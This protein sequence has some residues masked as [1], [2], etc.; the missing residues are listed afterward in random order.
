MS[1]DAILARSPFIIYQPGGT[2]TGLVVTSWTQVQKFIVAREGS[3]IVYI[4]DS[5]TSPATV[6]AATGITDGLGRL[7]IRPYRDNSDSFSTLVIDD[8]ATLKGILRIS[9]TVKVLADT[10]SATPGF[11]WDYSGAATPTV[12][13]EDGGFIG[14]TTTATNPSIVVPAAE[15]LAILFSNFGGVLVQMSTAFIN[16]PAATSTIR[17]ACSE[18]SMFGPGSTVPVPASWIT[19]PGESFISYDSRTIPTSNGGFPQSSAA[20][21]KSYQ[22]D[23]QQF[24]MIFTATTPNVLGSI[25]NGS[26]PFFVPMLPKIGSLYCELEG[27]GGTGGGGGGSAGGAANGVGGGGSGGATLQRA[28]FTANLTN[29]LDITIGAGGTAGAAGVAPAGAGG[30]G[31]DGGSTYA[32]DATT[33]FILALLGGTS[34]GQGGGAVGG[35]PGLGGAAYPGGVLIP[36]FSESLPTQPYGAGFMLAG[37]AGGLMNTAGAS[38]QGALTS[39]LLPSLD[40]VPWGGGPGGSSGAGEGGGGGGGGAGVIAPGSGGGS[41]QPS[42]TPGGNGGG[43]SPNSGTGVGGGAG[44]AGAADNG[45]AGGTGSAGWAKLRFFAP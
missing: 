22:S 4:D 17:I 11:D 34:G 9:G 42:G 21:Q 30:T 40:I 26:T 12:F 35:A 24:E 16:V 37:G 31:G 20:T 14:N 23:T 44:G 32:Q 18:A 15:S 1:Y 29:P 33:T 39:L 28:F 43:A 8:G 7:E 10:K 38:G 13:V 36:K 5:V 6:P 41:G 27:F 2:A 25:Q 45:G 3:A 19:G